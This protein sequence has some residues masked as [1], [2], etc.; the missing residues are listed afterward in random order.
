MA[1]PW[2]WDAEN[3]DLRSQLF[4]QEFES[5]RYRTSQK[6]LG[7]ALVN[8][9]VKSYG[10]KRED[11]GNW[12]WSLDNIATAF[13]EDPVWTT[14]DYATL[15]FAPARFGLAATA[16]ARGGSA[17]GAIGKGYKA[18]K[19]GVGTA[20]QLAA[21]EKA[22]RGKEA[23]GRL[24]R[25]F[26]KFGM[27]G[28]LAAATEMKLAGPGRLHGVRIPGTDSVWGL[29]NPITTQ[30]T[31]EYLG[32]VERFGAEV[33]ENQAIL[34]VQDR[35]RLIA[36]GMFARRAE[37]IS[38]MW[39]RAG[40]DSAGNERVMRLLDTK[41]TPD[42]LEAVVAREFAGNME[43]ANA[44][45]A[46]WAFRNTIHE[47]ARSLGL[48]SEETYQANLYKW[49][50]RLYEEWEEARSAL[51]VLKPRTGNK[52]PGKYAGPLDEGQ[53]AGAAGRMLS[54]EEAS[55]AARSEREHDY[56]TR[57]L[58]PVTSL[59]RM[60][61]AGQTI[62]R[63]AYAHG[64]ARSVLAAKPSD[65]L[66]TLVEILDKR[67]PRQMLLHGLTG[68]K[69]DEAMR[70]RKALT[71]ANYEQTA[72]QLLDVLGWRKAD[73]LAVNMPKALQGM[74]LDPRTAKDVIG[75]MN[76]M[77][78][79]PKWYATLYKNMLSTFRAS[80]TAYVPSTHVRNIFGASIFTAMATGD[81]GSM[82]PKKAWAAVKANGDD[83]K[84]AGEAGVIGS[85]FDLEIHSQLAKGANLAAR[86]AI[87]WLPQN[88]VTDVM[89]KG[90][91][92]AERFYRGVDET[93]KLEA[94]LRFKE[95]YEKIHGEGSELA[96]SLATV[97]VNKFLPNFL[98][99]SELM[100]AL[101]KGVPFASFTSE[102]LRVYKNL[103]A[104]KP[105]MVFFANHTAATMSQ[106]FGAM[107]GFSP[108]QV[109]EAQKALP[110]FMQGKKTLL[111]P[112]N[113]DGQPR[114][115]DL[116]YVIPMGSL[117][118]VDTTERVFFNAIL[119][120]STNPALNIASA[121]STGKDPFSGREIEPN[122][123]ERQLGIPVTGERTR[124]LLG[125][126]EHMLQTLLPPWAPPGYAG[127]NML[128]AIRGQ[129]NPKTGEPL[130]DGV[131]RTVLANLGG[132][133]TYAPDVESQIK[134]VQ[135]EQRR[136]GEQVSQ[137]WK[138]W[139]FAR[140]NGKL[141]DMEAERERIITL[142]TREGHD[143]PAGYFAES[144]KGR[145]LFS[146]LSTRQ[147]EEVLRRA[148]KL[149]ALSPRDERIRTELMARYQSRKAKTSHKK[150][151]DRN[152]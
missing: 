106:V 50:P 72:E 48:I 49:N 5:E 87:D 123:T 103:L 40:L 69:L 64:I 16:I 34:K 143:D 25:A 109:E 55:F 71:S 105:H 113:V 79:D 101:R 140:A 104:E 138:R 4:E 3:D 145:E 27:S 92:H 53:E 133:R 59:T 98:Q 23:A 149:G 63:E 14:L 74:Y 122:F 46:T 68:E 62:A 110:S 86:T 70:L 89:K 36:E 130:E 119:D 7:T 12:S 20:E 30:T 84:W 135:E 114:F 17:A 117:S 93:Y 6:G 29:A 142:K 65:A 52:I 56:L 102:A 125:L 44:Y 10:L 95:K 152:P 31:P 147:L 88:M 47:H 42:D 127:V 9:L 90:A 77:R 58:D 28:E 1:G 136:V 26:Q 148:E 126:G 54:G 124:R 118:E 21:A 139:E 66:G 99:H 100:D 2:G 57:I 83:L 128:E 67:D 37:D 150:E 8:E 115:L 45:K 112:F 82:I 111:L 39:G 120:P 73:E 13:K 60:A 33:W 137:A 97:D 38:R 80:K 51:G 85:S 129:I 24:G 94:W 81:L 107:A 22:F 141:G 91:A 75:V 15:M 76:F 131:F 96:R 19:T 108:E 134:N 18:L 41:V 151:P 132:L 61:Q 32:L 11:D 35:A 146:S 116:S 78:D 43:A 144:M 121:M